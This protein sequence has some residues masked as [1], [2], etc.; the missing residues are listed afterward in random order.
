M[1]HGVHHDHP[2]DPLRLV[3]PPSASVPL[4]LVFCAVFWLVL[5]GDD[6]DA[7]SAPASSPATSPTT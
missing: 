1:I 4:A 5:G 7:R 6:C 2:N 3:M